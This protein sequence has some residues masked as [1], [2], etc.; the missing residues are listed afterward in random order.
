MTNDYLPDSHN[1]VTFLQCQAGTKPIDIALVMGTG[2]NALTEHMP[3]AHTIS[4]AAIPGFPQIPDRPDATLSIGSIGAVRVAIMDARARYCDHGNIAAMRVPLETAH[5]MGAKAVVLA[6]VAGSLRPE[7]R[8]GAMVV[9]RD[10]MS[11]SGQSPLVGMPHTPV[12]DMSLAYDPIL[13]E[14]LHLAGSE[15]GRKLVDGVYWWQPGPQFETPAEVAAARMLGGDV[16][17]LSLNPETLIARHLGMRVLAFTMVTNFAAGLS[18]E[19]IT[20]EHIR[21][22]A[23]AGAGTMARLVT[24]FCELWRLQS[25]AVP[26]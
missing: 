22:V 20:R 25:L 24:K 5:L 1:A 2:M 11:F 15:I 16:I 23:S 3:D 8:P 12:C 14:R 6:S 17:G 13:R 4:F 7:L 26:N 21:R 19:T 10:H 18:D 9:I